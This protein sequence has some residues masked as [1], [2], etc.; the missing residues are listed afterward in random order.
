[1]TIAGTVNE[2][3][4]VVWLH[5]R[6]LNVRRATA[7]HGEIRT[8]LTVLPRGG[9]LLELRAEPALERGAWNLQLEYSGKIDDIDAAGMFSRS[10]NNATYLFTHF[11]PIYARRVFPCIDE[12][13]SKV[14]WR[15]T[16]DVPK[17][18]VA[19]SNTAIAADSLKGNRRRV[20]FEPTKPLPPHLLAFG[21][22]PF[23]VISAGVT[24]SGV[25]IHLF[26]LKGREAQTTY[27]A[28]TATALLEQLE[29]WVGVPFPF[30][31]LDFLVVPG[32]SDFRGM[33]NAGLIA[34]GQRDIDLE[35][36]PSWQRR[37][38]W[39]RTAT[40]QLARQWIG[41]LVTVAWWDDY[42]LSEGLAQWIANKITDQFQPSW[43]VE[44]E[45]LD[46]R[47]SA[48]ATDA[49]VSAREVRQPIEIVDDI[50]RAI[51]DVTYDKIRSIL[52]AF[53]HYLGRDALQRV[54][55][56]YV[57]DRAWETVTAADFVAALSSAT[58]ND[59]GP[60]FA[61]FFDQPGAPEIEVQLVCGSGPPRVELAQTR[62]VQAGS[63]VTP[64]TAQWIMPIC[65]AYES[66]GQRAEA[67]GL[68]DNAT[69]SLSLDLPPP[70]PGSE[71]AAC[72]Q[73][74]LTNARGA[75]YFYSRYTAAQ[76]ARLRDEAWPHLQPGERLALVHDVVNALL[77]GQV[78][79]RPP[80]SLA[81]SFVPKLLAAGDR[82]SIRQALSLSR[83]LERFVDD[84]QRPAFE[85][86]HRAT[87]GP[88]ARRLGL[89]PRSSDDLDTEQT[90]AEL[91]RAAA[92]SGRDRELTTQ[93][94]QYA[95]TWRQLPEAIRGVVLDIATSSDPQTFDRVRKELSS[96]PNRDHRALMIHALSQVRDPARFARALATSLA[97][98]LDFR[99]TQA[100]VFGSS[101]ETTRALAERFYRDHTADIDRR[102]QIDE[103]IAM[104]SAVAELFTD[105]CDAKR[106]DEI[107]GYL[108]Q[109]FAGRPGGEFFVKQ[110]AERLDQCIASRELLEPEIRAWLGRSVPEPSLRAESLRRKDAK[111]RRRGLVESARCHDGMPQRKTGDF[112]QIKR[113]GQHHDARR[114]D[115]PLR[116]HGLR[117]HGGTVEQIGTDKRRPADAH[118]VSIRHQ[119]Q[120]SI[121]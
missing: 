74:I 110:Q 113:R 108:E 89:T 111:S 51:D 37:M 119:H 90:R 80:L 73:W 55:R 9:D 27:A 39:I 23:D 88:S 81:L 107:V 83:A 16:L 50:F 1:M 76:F 58:N 84:T 36:H 96:E 15:L 2:R 13:D 47:A 46:I 59:V 17:G 25:A 29:A 97:P 35:E 68:F 12:P 7:S 66:A 5:G 103:G 118:L 45:E 14:P 44:L 33:A 112:L 101:T 99:E 114:F 85:A 106:R 4:S 38:R 56:S 71:L 70:S 116:L 104:P 87:F 31:K 61:T 18:Q 78:E 115:R 65:V 109:K 62:F 6:D 67:C 32:A 79:N 34:I 82:F 75:G 21:V 30:A 69:D 11:E 92:Q 20:V 120:R 105:A 53:G 91:V 117:I 48:L 24:D 95:R 54:V 49:L 60:G 77:N 57:A 64:D 3:S 19:V 26:T 100:I 10:V 98:D 93:A 52:N 72:P 94:V 43:Q 42:W 40:H 41:N 63:I 102:L 22:G 28:A 8:A 86:W 121:R